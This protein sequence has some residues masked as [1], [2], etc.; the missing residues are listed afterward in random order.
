MLARRDRPARPAVPSIRQSDVRPRAIVVDA[1]V[2]CI[3]AG[4]AMTV[5]ERQ[6][7]E[8]A[9]FLSIVMGTNVRVTTN[10]RPAWSWEQGRADCAVRSLGYWESE[11]PATMPAPGTAGPVQLRT[12]SRPDFADRG[13]EEQTLGEAM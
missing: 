5:F 1:Q 9:A 11:Q 12:V 8:T 3:G 13:L 2:E 4:D 7:Q 10:G 6:L